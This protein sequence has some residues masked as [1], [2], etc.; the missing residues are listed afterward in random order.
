MG[1]ELPILVKQHNISQEAII[2]ACN[3]ALSHIDKQL[4]IHIEDFKQRELKLSVDLQR[5][6]PLVDIKT[7]AMTALRLYRSAK[8]ANVS[9]KNIK[10]LIEKS[11][12]IEI[13]LSKSDF[14]S[15]EGLNAVTQCS[16]WSSRLYR[17][18]TL[19]KFNGLVTS[20]FG[21]NVFDNAA[22]FTKVDP[23]I[24][25]GYEFPTDQEVNDYIKQVCQRHKISF[26]FPP[27]RI[28]E[29]KT[30]YQS[31]KK[32]DEIIRR[33]TLDLLESFTNNKVT[34]IEAFARTGKSRLPGA[35]PYYEVIEKLR[36][37]GV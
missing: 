6:I 16:I 10:S 33:N 11:S 18:N 7:E 21:S 30:T 17:L 24:R 35:D 37:I 31:D 32:E 5:K 23:D 13:C 15:L 25:K 12:Q 26:D 34:G 29:S 4:E 36:K 1:N 9:K 19:P 20:V 14:T 2:E 28:E 8:S 27:N 3:E 22:F